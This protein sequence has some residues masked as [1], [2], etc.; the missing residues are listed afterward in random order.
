MSLGMFKYASMH[1]RR[2]ELQYP[3]SYL[4]ADAML[5]NVRG[6]LIPKDTIYIATDE[7]IDLRSHVRGYL[8]AAMC[9]LV[10]LPPIVHPGG[11][12]EYYRAI[13]NGWTP[14]H[15]TTLRLTPNS[16]LRSKKS[17]RLCDGVTS[18]TQ[19]AGAVQIASTSNP[20]LR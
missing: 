16:L 17:S 2:N 6:L 14:S 19:K 13:S 5:K 4:A 15:S 3:E 11:P 9:C 7:V 12:R 10:A 20:I 1:V 18:L 8:L